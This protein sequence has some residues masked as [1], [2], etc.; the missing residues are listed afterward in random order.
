MLD[1][2]IF[3]VSTSSSFVSSQSSSESEFSDSE[4]GFRSR[5]RLVRLVGF[6]QFLSSNRFLREQ[7]MQNLQGRSEKSFRPV[8]RGAG[9]AQA[10]NNFEKMVLCHK[11]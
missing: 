3:N 9:G 1:D 11:Y 6:P 4:S 5:L 10:P 2:S 8:G 7:I